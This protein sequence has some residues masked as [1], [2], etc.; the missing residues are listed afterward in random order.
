MQAA[1]SYAGAALV[2]K[3]AP[4]AIS[5]DL[6]GRH[7]SLAAAMATLE[8]LEETAKLFLLLRGVPTRTLSP[9]QI[10]ELKALLASKS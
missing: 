4:L 9:Q 2:G 10:D 8:E 3:P 5:F 6:G 7:Q 1:F